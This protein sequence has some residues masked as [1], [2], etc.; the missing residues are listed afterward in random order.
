MALFNIGQFALILILAGVS[1]AFGYSIG[2]N[3]TVHIHFVKDEDDVRMLVDRPF[4]VSV[5]P[6]AQD[7]V[8]K[9]GKGDDEIG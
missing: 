6:E 4:V 9:L 3:K 8:I 2:I 7:T 5:D 1:I